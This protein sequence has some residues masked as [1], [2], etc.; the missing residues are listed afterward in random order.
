[1]NVPKGP[2][3]LGNAIRGLLWIKKV[4]ENLYS[5]PVYMVDYENFLFWF[6]VW[7]HSLV[8]GKM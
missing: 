8:Y 3:W 5:N 7:I 6:P 4:A 1:M 2:I